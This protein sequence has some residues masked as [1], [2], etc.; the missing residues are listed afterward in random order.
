MKQSVPDL[1]TLCLQILISPRPPSNLPPLL[2][3]YAWDPPVKGQRHPLHD[4]DVLHELIPAV[5]SND[6]RRV[7]Q[8]LKSCSQAHNRHRDKRRGMAALGVGSRPEIFPQS[9]RPC[10]LDDA[11]ENPYYYPCPSPKHLEYSTDGDGDRPTRY[12]F[13]HPAEERIEWLKV[14]D[15]EVPIQWL[16]C[17]PG[18]LDY[19]EEEEEE[20]W[21]FSDEED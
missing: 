8:A 10:P 18:C 21:G 14:L 9:T 5:P 11:S 15:Q 4:P 19:L 3:D 13:I 6:L 7:L 12:L 17:S 20:E 16:G 1:Y 2:D